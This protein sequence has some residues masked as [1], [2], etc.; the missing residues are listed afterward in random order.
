MAL[1][2][3]CLCAAGARGAL[4]DMA[5]IRATDSLLVVAPHPDDE[6]L[7][8]AGVIHEARKAGA[9]VAIV[10]ITNGDGFRW[11][12]MVVN[13]EL[14]P[15]RASYLH[16]AWIRDGEAR[17]AARILDVAP[18]STY[19]LGY[20]DHGVGHLMADYYSPP[21]PWRSKYTGASSVAYP[22]S[23]DFGARYDG[24]NLTQDFAAVLDRVRPTLV[25]APSPRDTHPDHRGA[26]LLAAR[27]LAARGEQG[28]LRSWIVHGG[29]RWPRGGYAPDAPQTIPPTGSGLHWEQLRLD[30]GAT[31][32]KLAA[33]SA[34]RSQLEVMGHV[35]RRY[36][37]STELF[38]VAPPG[39]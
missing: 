16:L 32:A 27:V 25:F 29:M 9:R 10:W 39:S 24:E 1:L 12:D 26:G 3:A 4:P 37:R 5:P 20:P 30:P 6:S 22:G 35:M 38:A 17:A 28:K 23:F 34:H 15:D 7:C 21:S 11:D 31:A 2:L 33:I 14:L 36:V 13:H 18:E 19:F 8:C